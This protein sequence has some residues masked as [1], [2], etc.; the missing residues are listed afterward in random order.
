[1]HHMY[2]CDTQYFS[3]ELCQSCFGYGHKKQNDCRLQARL[4][5]YYL[6]L[7]LVWTLPA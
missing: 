3:F 4:D 5:Y 6:G 2:N 7:T 1:M